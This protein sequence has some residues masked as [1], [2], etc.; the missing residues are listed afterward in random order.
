MRKKFKKTIKKSLVDVV[1]KDFCEHGIYRPLIKYGEVR[2]DKSMTLKIVGTRIENSNLFPLI[3]NG[4][5][6]AK[7]GW[8]KQ[9]VN[10]NGRSGVVYKI[11][12][13]ETNCKHGKLIFKADSKLSN[14]VHET[15]KNTRNYYRI[16]K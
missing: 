12:L 4:I 10:Y 5:G 8:V 13:E 9:G 1:W 16:E 15:L 3:V 14:R 6:I 2:V 7:K 11:V